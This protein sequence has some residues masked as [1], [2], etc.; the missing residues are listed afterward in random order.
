MFSGIYY[1]FFEAFAFHTLYKTARREPVRRTGHIRVPFLFLTVDEPAFP[2]EAG[3]HRRFHR[4]GLIQD[5]S[6]RMG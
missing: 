5:R 1:L 4:F 6:V 3:D 2:V